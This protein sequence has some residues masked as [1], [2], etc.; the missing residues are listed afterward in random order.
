MSNP[1]EPINAAGRVMPFGRSDSKDNQGHNDGEHGRKHDDDHG[2][3][4]GSGDHDDHHGS[5]DHNDESGDMHA[6]LASM[7][8]VTSVLDFAVAH[9]DSTM[10]TFDVTSFDTQDTDSSLLGS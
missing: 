10:T 2:G 6:V 4:K 3:H 8:D 9:L 7:T 1:T 5:S